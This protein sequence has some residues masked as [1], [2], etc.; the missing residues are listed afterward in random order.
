MTQLSGLYSG[1]QNLKRYR[2]SVRLGSAAAVFGTVVLGVLAAAFIL[3][4]TTHMGRLE[5]FIMLVAFIAATVWSARKH[6]LPALAV[7]EDPTTLALMVERQQGISSDLVA[8]MQF[9]DEARP[10]IGSAD[11]RNAVVEYTGEAA[12]H[13]DY[14]EGF[15]REELKKRGTN[16]GILAAIVLLGMLIMPGHAM[17]FFNR[18]LLGSAH[19]PTRTRIVEVMSP[20]DRAAYGQPIRFKIRVGGELPESGS[21]ELTALSTGLRTEV[22][23]TPDKADA[24]LYTG[25]L[26]RAMDDVSYTIHLGD[27]YTDARELALTPV[28]TVEVDM[29]IKTPD[30]AS[31]KFT[32]RSYGRETRIALEGSTVTATMKSDKPL[33]SAT[34]TIDDKPFQMTKRGDVWVLPKGTPFDAV[35]ATMR[36]EVQVVDE[37]DLSLER[38]ISGVMQVRADQPPRVKAATVTRYVLPTATPSISFGAIDDYALDRVLVHKSV[39]R[40]IRTGGEAPDEKTDT[41]LEF[42]GKTDQHA[43]RIN[44]SLTDLDLRKGDR[45]TLAF[46]AYDYRGRLEGR[47]TRSEQIVFEVTDRAGVL[48]A[49]RELDTQMDRKLDQIIKAQLGIGDNP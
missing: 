36:Y 1:L 14:L 35:E 42:G 8:A 22:E 12:S 17:A 23:L 11:L 25:E 32:A 16:F 40:G 39:T 13:L 7:D 5:R 29:S 41:L 45:V 24:N 30:Y 20:G 47:G 18:F 21:V 43:D 2:A 33:K 6:L 49:L 19:Y 3:D 9:A 27:A 15:D 28:P 37:D 34:F 46:E 26:A 38:P 31:E 48:A 10:Q 44:V 4:V